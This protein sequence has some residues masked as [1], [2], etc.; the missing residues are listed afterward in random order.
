MATSVLE[1]ILRAKNEASKELQRVTQELKGIDSTAK[2][3]AGG[4]SAL[5]GSFA[6]QQ[7]VRFSVEMANL[8]TTLERSAFAFEHFSG[9]ADQA[10]TNMRA[11]QRAAGGMLTSFEAQNLAVMA[12]TQNLASNSVELSRI[13]R[14]ARGIVAVSPVIND[15]DSAFSQLGLTIA[16]Q[17]VQ[18]LDQLGTSA[19]EIIPKVEA[20]KAANK[21]LTD[22]QAFQAA[23]LGTLETKFA[24]LTDAA[25]YQASE[26]ERLSVAW[27]N[28]R[29]EA[30]RYFGFVNSIAGYAADQL[31]TNALFDIGKR[32]ASEI[33]KGISESQQAVVEEINKILSDPFSLRQPT[34]TGLGYREDA[35]EQV[36][37]LTQEYLRLADAIVRSQ[38]LGERSMEGP[39]LP[40]FFT[41]EDWQAQIDANIASAEEAQKAIDKLIETQARAAEAQAFDSNGGD[42]QKAS[43]IYA[44]VVEQLNAWVAKQRRANVEVSTIINLLPQVASGAINVQGAIAEIDA[45]P[46]DQLSTAMGKLDLATSTAAG[47]F[48]A[49][50]RAMLSSGATALNVAGAINAAAGIMADLAD[51]RSGAKYGGLSGLIKT[52]LQ[53]G[54]GMKAIAL[55]SGPAFAGVARV[56]EAFEDLKSTVSGIVTGA[57]GPVAGVDANDLL[58]RPDAINENARRLADIA[59]NGLKGQDWLEEFKAEVPGVWDEISS[60]GDPQRA[61]AE[62]LKQFQDG[63][64]PELIDKERAKELVR[65]ALE[66]DS[67]TKQLI[68][69]IAADLANE[70]GVSLNDAKS[71]ASQVLGGSGGSVTGVSLA[72]TVDAS[73]ASSAASS[74]AVAFT[75]AI[76]DGTLGADLSGAVYAQVVGSF[77]L[78]EQSGRDA[79]NG[80]AQGFMSGAGNL[81]SS[82]IGLIVGLVTPGVIAN[83]NQQGTRTGPAEV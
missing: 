11:V 60:S 47:K 59:V 10:A 58:P 74:F 54:D 48:A 14:I 23:L 67:N 8:N 73:A 15:L 55:E 38:N 83:I 9:G 32:I 69:E 31:D 30:A 71:A 75:S 37:A 50:N 7:A 56:N 46:I 65:T 45:E 41:G 27:Q 13:T 82:V 49:L 80:W 40:A 12:M 28:Y 76:E 3:V 57:I 44:G 24:D 25:I 61:A 20:L 43:A 5:A 22:E 33:P 1:M 66:A 6:V 4:L 36:A 21:K 64:R 78:I 81:P 52:P 68:D 63:L 35:R 53:L 26:M 19:S 18:R 70:L 72:P 17:S 42:V 2:V 79:G 16:N 34:M 51:S 39:S 29:T 77:S 62:V